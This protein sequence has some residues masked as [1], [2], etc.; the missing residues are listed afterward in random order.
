MTVYSV[1]DLSKLFI[2]LNHKY[3]KLKIQLTLCKELDCFYLDKFMAAFCTIRVISGVQYCKLTKV[4][5][6]E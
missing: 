2:F 3:S 6:Y 5:T 4:R 1:G